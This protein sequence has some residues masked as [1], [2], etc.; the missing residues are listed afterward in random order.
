MLT[1]TPKRVRAIAACADGLG[2]PRGSLM[3]RHA[4]HVV[5]YDSEEAISAKLEYLKTMFRWSDAEVSTVVSR[6]SFALTKSKESLQ[7]TSEFLIS[8]M[9]LKPDYIAHWPVIVSLSLKD[10]FKPRYYVVKFLKENRLLD[11]D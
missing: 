3:F 1:N 2:V 9:G 10:R 8:E 11:H 6:A 5:T 4:L 7:H